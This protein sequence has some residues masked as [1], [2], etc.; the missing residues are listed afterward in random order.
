MH[1]MRL[2]V[3]QEVIASFDGQYRTLQLPDPADLVMRGIP[4]ERCEY[5]LTPAFWAAQ[6]WMEGDPPADSF[7]LGASLAE[8]IAAC[9]LGGYGIPA[10][11]GLAAFY[12]VREAMRLDV[13]ALRTGDTLERLLSAP[14]D[15]GGRS[16][17]YRFARQKARYLL[18]CL[19]A[20]SELRTWDRYD[21]R[22]LRDALLTLPGIGYKTASWI[23]RNWR[24][25]D[26]VA[27]IDIHIVRACRLLNLFPPDA[28]PSRHYRKL[29]QLFLDFAASIRVRPSLLDGVMWRTMRSL[30]SALL[31]L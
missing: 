16:V 7:R 24:A 19:N 31:P 26:R 1:N 21:D 17:R 13:D 23:V 18:S 25:S 4:W 11:I 30:P 5:L 28:D 9:L 2:Q 22:S 12:R 15:V 27:I 3:M 20:L 29:E 10:E 8:E 6:V 14:L